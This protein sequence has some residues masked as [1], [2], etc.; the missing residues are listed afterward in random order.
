[1]SFIRIERSANQMWGTH[2]RAAS[3]FAPGSAAGAPARESACCSCSACICGMPQSIGPEAD[4]S[5]KNVAVWLHPAV[6]SPVRRELYV[7]N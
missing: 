7:C 3:R 4:Y 1:M 6:V 2:S 5:V